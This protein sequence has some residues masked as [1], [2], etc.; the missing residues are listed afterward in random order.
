[1]QSAERLVIASA[2]IAELCKFNV[3]PTTIVLELL[4]SCVKDFHEFLGFLVASLLRV[5][6]IYI[7]VKLQ[8]YQH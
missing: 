7:E 3:C 2:L 5:V 6:R 8:R 1:M 4:R